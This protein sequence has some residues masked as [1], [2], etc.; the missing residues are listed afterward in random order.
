MTFESQI[1][2]VIMVPADGSKPRERIEPS[3]LAEPLHVVAMRL[4]PFRENPYDDRCHHA[5]GSLGAKRFRIQETMPFGTSRTR[6]G[7]LGLQQ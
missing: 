3:E 2:E 4:K 7:A 6:G 1:Y 5:V